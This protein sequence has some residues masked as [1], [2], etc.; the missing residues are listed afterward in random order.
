MDMMHEVYETFEAMREL[1]IDQTC[2]PI[3]PVCPDIVWLAVHV[4]QCMGA[5]V[6]WIAQALPRTWRWSSPTSSPTLPR[7]RPDKCPS[8]LRPALLYPLIRPPPASEPEQDRVARSLPLPNDGGYID[9][10]GGPKV[11]TPDD[12]DVCTPVLWTACLLHPHTNPHRGTFACPPFSVPVRRP[13][14]TEEDLDRCEMLGDK[15]GEALLMTQ[16]RY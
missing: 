1:G 16:D 2:R 3:P 10:M 8:L 9:P 13:Q 15:A 12:V 5:V 6:G 4:A 11:A 14:A 7:S